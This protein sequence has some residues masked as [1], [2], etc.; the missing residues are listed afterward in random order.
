VWTTDARYLTLHGGMVS[1]GEEH[2]SLH[3][4]V[5]GIS[6]KL[7]ATGQQAEGLR[8]E[9]HQVLASL[10]AKVA[11]LVQ[12]RDNGGNLVA[13]RTEVQELKAEHADLESAILTLSNAVTSLMEVAARSPSSD[14]D[15]GYLESCFT[16]YDAAVNG[17]LD[18]IRHQMKGG[19]ITV[20]G[21]AFSDR[22]AAMGW[23]RIHLPPNTYQALGAWSTPCA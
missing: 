5:L 9:V 1:L 12:S 20:E 10:S 21:V 14:L 11:R 23:A 18:S 13:L 7:K 8:V 16:A 2:A 22:E 19:G 17:R 3:Q 15:Q 4:D 6:H